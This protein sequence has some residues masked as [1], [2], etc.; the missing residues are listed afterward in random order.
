MTGYSAYYTVMD[1]Q[2][3]IPPDRSL[4]VETGQ[5]WHSKSSFNRGSMSVL[6]H[7]IGRLLLGRKMALDCGRVALNL[8]HITHGDTPPS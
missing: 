4:I 1:G 6:T 7:F 5:G 3:V 2:Y 8:F